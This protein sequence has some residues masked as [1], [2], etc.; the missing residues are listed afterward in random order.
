MREPVDSDAVWYRGR[1]VCVSPSKHFSKC[2]YKPNNGTNALGGSD[3]GAPQSVGCTF[4]YPGL[5]TQRP[6]KDNEP[7]FLSF[8]PSTIPLSVASQ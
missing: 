5:V 7:F 1:R 8:F 6:D 3:G 4:N 2:D